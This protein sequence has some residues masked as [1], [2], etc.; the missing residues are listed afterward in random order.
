M[1]LLL[2]PR[3]L[4]QDA[5]HLLC[6]RVWPQRGKQLT[7]VRNTCR[8][9]LQQLYQS[10]L[11]LKWFQVRCQLCALPS[12]VA[13]SSNPTLHE[14]GDVHVI[15]LWQHDL[16]L[17]ALGLKHECFP[18]LKMHKK[19]TWCYHI[20]CKRG[21]KM[22]VSQMATHTWNY[23]ITVAKAPQVSPYAAFWRVEVLVQDHQVS[24][25]LDPPAEEEEVHSEEALQLGWQDASSVASVLLHSLGLLQQP[26]QLLPQ[27]PNMTWN[28]KHWPGKKVSHTHMQII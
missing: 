2:L 26:V 17:A 14:L 23:H 24:Y 9:R 18:W 28:D 4:L 6:H 1:C 20:E 8:R 5:S 21:E 13:G 12:S 15:R 3:N 11:A 22:N 16:Q 25:Y 27:L 19:M 10:L 7:A